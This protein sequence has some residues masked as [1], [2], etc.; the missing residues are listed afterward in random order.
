[1]SYAWEGPLLLNDAEQPMSG[2]KHYDNLY[3]VAELPASK[4]EVR[5]GEW[6][7]RLRFDEGEA[8]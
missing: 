6:L 7:L 5:F 1:M 2:F 3:C 8:G 4:I